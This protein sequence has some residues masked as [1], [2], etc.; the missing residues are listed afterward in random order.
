[1]T[2]TTDSPN[3]AL[4]FCYDQPDQGQTL[5]LAQP[6]HACTR[7]TD[8]AAYRNV[9]YCTGLPAGQMISVI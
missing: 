2:E 4:M 5:Q 1:V 3:K 6:E 7:A 8:Q 9:I